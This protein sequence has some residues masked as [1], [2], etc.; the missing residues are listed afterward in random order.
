[1]WNKK[2]LSQTIKENLAK[3]N[4]EAVENACRIAFEKGGLSNRDK[5]FLQKGFV[6]IAEQYQKN[7][8]YDSSVINYEYAKILNPTNVTYL[9]NQLKIIEIIYNNTKDNLT[10]YDCQMLDLI[11]FTLVAPYKSIEKFETA[12]SAIELENELINKITSLLPH[13]PKK[14]ESL[15]SFRLEKILNTI[16]SLKFSHLSPDE[17]VKEASKYL[18]KGLR[19]VLRKI[20][21][22]KQNKPS[23]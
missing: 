5:N 20:N 11:L 8:E 14:E 17:R 22:E 10:N 15:I 19:R 13:A 1:M 7:V 16:A 3:G 6:R 4:F 12:L 2:I 23:K 21:Q 9:L 18:G